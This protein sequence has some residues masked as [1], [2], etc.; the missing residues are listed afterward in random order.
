MSDGPDLGQRIRRLPREL[1]DTVDA[2]LLTVLVGRMSVPTRRT[3]VWLRGRRLP[4]VDPAR[5]VH[6]PSPSRAAI[7]GTADRV[8]TRYATQAGFLGL[9]AGIGGVA[10]IPPEVLASAVG[11]YRLA[12]RLCVVYGFDPET[13]R[14][15]MALW[16]ALAQAYGLELPESGVVSMRA[17]Q[18]PGLLAGRAAGQ[19]ENVS[20]ALTRAALRT[21][22]WRVAGRVS[23]FVPVV[24]ALTQSGRERRQFRAI[25]GEMKRVLSRLSEPAGPPADIEDA[26]ELDAGDR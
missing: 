23:R 22:A 3:R 7:D 1:A 13:D 8:I 10:S 11:A 12:Q 26:V 20:G 14:G 21:T 6:A 24:A 19:G 15:Q 9:A 4:F 17:S 25:G 18:L 2:R 5:P 16:Q